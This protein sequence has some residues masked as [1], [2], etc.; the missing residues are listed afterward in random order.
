MEEETPLRFAERAYGLYLASRTDL[1][2]ILSLNEQSRLAGG[3]EDDET[4]LK[5]TN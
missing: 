2:A 1:L 3:E 5:S 4:T